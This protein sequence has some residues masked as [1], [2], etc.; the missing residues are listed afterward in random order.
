MQKSILI[1]GVPR[2]GTTSFLYCFDDNF[3]IYNEPINTAIR[4]DYSTE[5]FMGIIKRSNIVVKTMA[6]QIPFD[7]SETESNSSCLK[8]FSEIIPFFDKIILIDRKDVK[9]QLESFTKMIEQMSKDSEVLKTGM[10]HFYLNKLNIRQISE[11]YNLPIFYYEDIFYG[12]S[13][14]IFKQLDIP[15]DLVN[16]EFLDKKYKYQDNIHFQKPK[17]IL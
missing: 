17:T 3:E 11:K 14:D 9:S 2:S 12:D 1:I 6:D 5:R 4:K 16:L 8:F 13:K 10:K 7:Y 15:L